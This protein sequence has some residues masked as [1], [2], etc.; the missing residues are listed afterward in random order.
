MHG[1]DKF[2]FLHLLSLCVLA[3]AIIAAAVGLVFG[4]CYLVGWL[5]TAVLSG[6][7]YSVPFWP[8]VGAVFL[9]QLVL[10]MVCSAFRQK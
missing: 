1:R 2:G 3:I 6:F 8:T 4:W 5:A 7:G 10:G 9:S